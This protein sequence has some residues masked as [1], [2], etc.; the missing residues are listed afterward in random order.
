MCIVFGLVGTLRASNVGRFF[1]G[2]TVGDDAEVHEQAVAAL[3][4]RYRERLG[5]LTEQAESLSLSGAAEDRAWLRAL[6]VFLKQ[7]LGEC[8]YHDEGRL[9]GGLGTSSTTIRRYMTATSVDPDA[10]PVADVLEMLR[11][12]ESQS[13]SQELSL[14]KEAV[15]DLLGRA[16]RFAEGLSR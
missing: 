12:I 16:T 1:R 14:G 2:D 15:N 5:G 6:S 8:C 4:Q 11:T 7:L 13:L 9:L 10:A 3:R